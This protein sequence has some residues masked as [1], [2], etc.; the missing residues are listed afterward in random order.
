MRKRYEGLLVN[1]PLTA[2]VDGPIVFKFEMN[3][4]EV[5]ELS[6]G[7]TPQR[8]QETCAGMLEWLAGDE[9][10]DSVRPGSSVGAR[11]LFQ[12]EAK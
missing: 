12:Q 11:A 2:D 6:E 4:A 10:P 1:V 5:R 8:V 9:A 7:R 3:E